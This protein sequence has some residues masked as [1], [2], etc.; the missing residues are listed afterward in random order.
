MKHFILAFLLLY[1]TPTIAQAQVQYIATYEGDGTEADPFRAHSYIRGTE[2]KSLRA[3]ETKADGWA[4]CVGP[5]LPARAG[6]INL[7]GKRPLVKA[8]RDKI[9][10]DSGLSVS[11]TTVDGLLSELVDSQGVSLK[12]TDGRQKIVV[13][14][15]E[16]WSRP[17]PL[18]SYLPDAWQF[19]KNLIAGPVVWAAATI[20]E[21]WNCADDSTS[22]FVCDHT[23]VR[24]VGTTATLASNSL[25]N[26]NSVGSNVFYNE[27]VLDSTDMR[28]LV[29]V[30]SISRGTATNVA[31]GAAVRHAGVGGSTY[32]Y[33]VARDAASTEIE[34]GHVTAGALTT[35][36]TVSATVADGD[37]VESI[38]RGDQI[39]CK[40]NGVLVLGPLTE[41]N[42]SGNVLIGLRFSGAGT[43]TTTLVVLDDAIAGLATSTTFGPFRRRVQ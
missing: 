41:N 42:G 28:H 6:I 34:Y 16:V 37:T 35:D 40:H 19:V 3:D 33:C 31:G 18:S 7:S 26:V 1:L 38:A 23:W 14:G 43:A 22:P 21:D 27:T 4:Y 39:S 20:T 8:D 11:S 17:A 29:T 9:L 2:C 30:S 12:R 36:G 24:S 13:K 32:N 10:S 15:L 25:R 5:S